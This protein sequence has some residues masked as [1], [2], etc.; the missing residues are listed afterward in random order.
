MKRTWNLYQ[1]T[2]YQANWLQGATVA[3]APSVEHED[4]RTPRP[5]DQLKNGKSFDYDHET[6]AGAS[7]SNP[8][9]QVKFAL[10]SQILPL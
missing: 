10:L 5:A 9:L 3:S 7:D 1:I 6:S 2:Q 8:L 4:Y